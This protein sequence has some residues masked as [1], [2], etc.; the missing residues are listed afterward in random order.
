MRSLK[1]LWRNAFHGFSQCS[2]GLQAQRCGGA[3]PREARRR[4]GQVQRRAAVGGGVSHRAELSRASAIGPSCSMMARPAGE[5]TNPI[6]AC[7]AG[8]RTLS[9]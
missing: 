9:L 1:P 2:G 3:V 5:N 7:A 6:R 4:A 8:S